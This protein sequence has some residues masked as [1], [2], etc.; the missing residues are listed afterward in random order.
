MD[1]IFDIEQKQNSQEMLDY[2]NGKPTRLF[3]FADEF[4]DVARKALE[5][6]V[7]DVKLNFSWSNKPEHRIS[8][9]E[10][11][12]FMQL[13]V[14][15]FRAEWMLDNTDEVWLVINRYKPKKADRLGKIPKYKESGFKHDIFDN[16]TKAQ[17]PSEI[18]ISQK[19]TPLYFGQQYYFSPFN[20][21]IIGGVKQKISTEIK[22]VKGFVNRIERVGASGYGSK[23]KNANGNKAWTY[24]QFSIKVVKGDNVFYSNP[25]ATI[26]MIC[27]IEQNGIHISYK[28]K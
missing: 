18:L 8:T 15:D 5:A 13:L 7:H 25:K 3:L 19:V 12:D 6:A 4:N 1:T 22:E 23:N 14:M 16:R 26:Q 11:I 21:V 28:L 24:L 10:G 2:A 27:H 20:K 17:R 9:P